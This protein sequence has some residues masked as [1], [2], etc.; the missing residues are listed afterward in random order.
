MESSALPNTPYQWTKREMLTSGKNLGIKTF[1]E[2][3]QK[4]SANCS[5]IQLD[6][7]PDHINDRNLIS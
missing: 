6:F 2:T 5:I 3:Q 7:A 4:F 1:V